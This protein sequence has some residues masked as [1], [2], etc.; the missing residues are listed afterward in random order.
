MRLC[1]ESFPRATYELYKI[2]EIENK[3]HRDNLIYKT[4]NK[5]KDETNDFQKFEAIRSFGREIYNNY[6]S[7]DDALE[8]QIILKDEINIFKEPAKLKESIRKEKKA[9]TFK[10]TII[11]LNGRQKVQRL[12]IALAQV[13]AGSTSSK[14]SY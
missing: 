3:L 12:L 2:V 11:L 14:R 1:L 10:N 4:G 8:L 9:L 6:L 5:K 13:K 7:L